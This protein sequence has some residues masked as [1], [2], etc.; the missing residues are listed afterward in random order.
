MTK[1]TKEVSRRRIEFFLTAGLTALMIILSL[2]K[3]V[4]IPISEVRLL[5]LSFVPVMFVA[6][7]GG[8]RVAIPVGIAWWGVTSYQLV[9]M[10]NPAWVFITKMSFCL[11]L[12]HL[13]SIAKKAFPCSP[14]NVYRAVI[15][16]I[17]I[18]NIFVGIAMVHMYP[19][20]PPQDW[21]RDT[22][23]GFLIEMALSL[24]AMR[25]LID[26]LRQ[27]HILNGIKRK[28]KK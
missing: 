1:P 22:T 9:D 28:N 26:H 27:I 6:M 7:I 24:L 15:G 19:E 14:W 8:Y 2:S 12:V 3:V 5:D 23:I 13:Y 11:A 18:R 4:Y 20:V 25:L 17:T 10:Y 21:L 16:A